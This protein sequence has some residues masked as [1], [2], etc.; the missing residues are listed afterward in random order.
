MGGS[1]ENAVYLSSAPLYHAAPLVFSMSWQRLGATVIVMERFE[2]RQCLELIERYRI[3]HTQMVPTMF[4][5]L[6][7]LP[8]TERAGHDT[9]SLDTGCN[10]TT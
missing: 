2:P 3:T 7:R 9:S 10:T 5:R 4:V 6:L 1:T 8:P